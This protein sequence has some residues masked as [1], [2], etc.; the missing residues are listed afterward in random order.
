MTLDDPSSAGRQKGARRPALARPFPAPPGAD[1]GV[2]SAARRWL[3]LSQRDLA[4]TAVF[5]APPRVGRAA[6][7]A[8]RRWRGHSQRHLALAGL[9]LAPLGAGYLGM[10]LRLGLVCRL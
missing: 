9:F 10:G 1:G 6:S 8:A 5:P 3:G 7:S 2:S 4:L